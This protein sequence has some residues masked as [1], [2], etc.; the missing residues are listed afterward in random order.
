M[1]VNYRFSKAVLFYLI[2]SIGFQ[3]TADAQTAAQ[4]TLEIKKVLKN[5]NE[6]LVAKYGPKES[7]TE[8]PKE[9][10][11]N[12]NSFKIK[13]DW[14]EIKLNKSVTINGN[15]SSDNS[16]SI[17][18][19][20]LN[21][22]TYRLVIKKEDN[23]QVNR[24]FVFNIIQYN[25]MVS[26]RKDFI[27]FLTEEETKVLDNRFERLTEETASKEKIG[28]PYAITLIGKIKSGY[29]FIIFSTNQ[30]KT[31][32]LEIT[33]SVSVETNNDLEKVQTSYIKTSKK[34]K[35]TININ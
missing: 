12:M 18:R 6:E 19:L 20:E 14:Y 24:N 11:G 16:N 9:F 33:Q 22:I 7:F 29:F 21:D 3:L 8:V 17:I 25:S 2:T 1:K 28:K 32:K 13:N 15:I 30:Y 5:G 35:Q 26:S 4:Y 23:N 10:E 31:K 27:R 34:Y